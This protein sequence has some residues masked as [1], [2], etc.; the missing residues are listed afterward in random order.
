MS[1]TSPGVRHVAVVLI[2]IEPA[3]QKLVARVVL[4]RLAAGGDL[5][6][7]RVIEYVA[8]GGI[9]GDEG[10]LRYVGRAGGAVYASSLGFDDGPNVY[11]YRLS[12]TVTFSCSSVFITQRATVVNSDA[13]EP[14]FGDP[15]GCSTNSSTSFFEIPEAAVTTN[16]AP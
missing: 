12:K 4:E 9:L 6:A 15:S 3:A 16:F 5:V 7:R 10:K 11:I 8:R 1:N 13:V 14:D 2:R